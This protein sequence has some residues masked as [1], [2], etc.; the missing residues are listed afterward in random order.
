MRV[1]V[2]H[3]ACGRSELFSLRKRWHSDNSVPRRRKCHYFGLSTQDDLRAYTLSIR[4]CNIDILRILGEYLRILRRSLAFFFCTATGRASKLPLLC[5]FHVR[6]QYLRRGLGFMLAIFQD[7]KSGPLFQ[8]HGRSGEHA[9]WIF[10]RCPGH[11]IDDSDGNSGGRLHRHRHKRDVDGVCSY[12]NGADD[13]CQRR[14]VCDI[15]SPRA[16]HAGCLFSSR[17]GLLKPIFHIES[18]PL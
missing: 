3:A 7:C 10:W 11:G 9:L 18:Q 2:R 4:R 5:Q 8:R 14:S 12:H 6:A 1:K 13:C 17:A 15:C 16:W